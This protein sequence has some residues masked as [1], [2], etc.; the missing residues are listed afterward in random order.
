ME[1]NRS[2]GEGA[3]VEEKEERVRKEEERQG[4]VEN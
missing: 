1:G 2:E 4:L 3:K